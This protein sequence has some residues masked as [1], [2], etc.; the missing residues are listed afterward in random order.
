MEFSSPAVL[1]VVKMTTY[2]A[3]NDENFV[4]IISTSL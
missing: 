4:N 2:H 1:G 3:A